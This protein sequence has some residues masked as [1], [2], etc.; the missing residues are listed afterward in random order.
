MI[1]GFIMIVL[2]IILFFLSKTHLMAII[3]S[4]GLF[5]I[6]F[7]FLFFHY[8]NDLEWLISL[9][10]HLWIAYYYVVALIYG[11]FLNEL[12]CGMDIDEKEYLN[13]ISDNDYYE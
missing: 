5:G 13:Y 6:D 1:I 10:F 2:I 4:F 7:I 12:S 11:K 8:H 3:I 9:I